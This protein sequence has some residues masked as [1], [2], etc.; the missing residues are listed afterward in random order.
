MTP[1]K[2]IDTF[3]IALHPAV[4]LVAL[5][6][7]ESLQA[8]KKTARNLIALGKYP[9]PLTR[10]LGKQRVLTEDL[11]NAVRKRDSLDTQVFN[12]ST[13][14]HKPGRPRKSQMKEVA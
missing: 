12:E 8:A 9:L 4:A 7:S 2:N 1:E 3:Q 13:S 5:A 10:I 11:W 14:R 6:Y